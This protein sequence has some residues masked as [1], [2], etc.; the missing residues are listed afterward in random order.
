MSP[1]AT[2]GDRSTG[3]RHVVLT[4]CVLLVPL[5]Q[6]AGLPGL[7]PTG[8]DANGTVLPPGATDPHYVVLDDDGSVAPAFVVTTLP[9]SYASPNDHSAW[10][11]EN[12]DGYPS[13]VRRTYRLSFDLG[14]RDTDTLRIEGLWST[15]DTG[16]DILVNGLSTQHTSPGFGDFR[17][18]VLTDG[19]RAGVNTID[20]VVENYGVVGAFRVDAIAAVPEPRTAVLGIAG[21]FTL[22]R[23]T[24]Q[25]RC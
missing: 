8:V 1:F 13:H 7:H 22:L 20:F 17:P 21:L 23:V 18:F 2:L 10:I 16:H 11:W 12:A 3:A 4:V 14:T 5:A 24:R 6:A 25:R 15:D 19:W 9:W